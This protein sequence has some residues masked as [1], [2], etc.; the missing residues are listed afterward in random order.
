MRQKK[1]QKRGNEEK[2]AGGNEEGEGEGTRWK[3]VSA[4]EGRAGT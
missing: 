1:E 4:E 3:G 2:E